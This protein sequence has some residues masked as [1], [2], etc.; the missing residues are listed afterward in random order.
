MRPGQVRWN[1]D[2][3]GLNRLMQDVF[4]YTL[5]FVIVYLV[6]CMVLGALVMSVGLLAWVVLYFGFGISQSGDDI[7]VLGGP[8]IGLSIAFLGS[9]PVALLATFWIAPSEK[10]MDRTRRRYRDQVGRPFDRPGGPIDSDSD[11]IA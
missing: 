11:A 4:N 3:P 9:I 2:M 6:C 5:H 1:E 7:N 8:G 10:N